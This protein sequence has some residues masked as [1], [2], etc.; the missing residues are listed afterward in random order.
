MAKIFACGDIVNC[1]NETGSVCSEDIN[2]IIRQTD[3]AICNFEAPI[4]GYGTP[5]RKIG[6]HIGQRPETLKGLKDQGFNLTLLANNHIMDFGKDALLATK[7]EA[8]HS[9]LQTIGASDSF[10]SAYSPLVEEIEGLKIGFINACEAQFGVIDHFE[11]ATQEGYAWINHPQIDKT[12]LNLRHECDFIIVFA[13]AG[14]ENYS[15]PQKEWR[16]RYRHLCDLGAD[17]I[18]GSHPHVPQGYEAHDNSF[19][20]YSLGNFYFDAGSWNDTDDRSFAVVLDLQKGHLPNFALVQHYTKDR[21]VH[22]TPDKMQVDIDELCEKLGTH[23]SRYHN[24]MALKAYPSIRKNLMQSLFP[25]P[26]DATI[27]G[28]F[29][30][31][32]AKALGRRKKIDKHLLQLHLLRNESYYYAARHALELYAHN[33]ITKKL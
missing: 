30:E 32:A 18:I 25:L 13:H 24:I 7:A 15:I 26:V 3:Y 19:I 14:L 9:G 28:T 16:A 31:I 5:L 33:T 20:F 10:E 8:E 22:I 29:K 4:K 6:P 11:R 2:E 17:V 23:Y 1:R 12:I 27:G 21:R